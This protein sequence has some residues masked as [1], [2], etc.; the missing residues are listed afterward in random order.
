MSAYERYCEARDKK[1]LKDAHVAEA[2]SIGRSTFS[3]WKSG[4][5]TPK[6]E[7]LQKIADYLGVSV[8]WILT[9]ESPTGYYY[10]E[11]A[12]QIAQEIYQN[13]DLHML[14]DMTRDATADELRD[15]AE[16]VKLMKKRERYEDD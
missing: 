9:G 7:K 10:N 11:D 16:M 8:E 4:R 2:T 6:P 15:F 14:F 13:K 12:M 3:D 5:S 1:G